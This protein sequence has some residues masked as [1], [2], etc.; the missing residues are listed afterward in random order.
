LIAIIAV[1]ILIVNQKKQFIKKI[2][3]K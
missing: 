3:N 1:I 2:K